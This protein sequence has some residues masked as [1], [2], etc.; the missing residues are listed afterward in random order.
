MDKQLITFNKKT[1][2][3]II[4]IYKHIQ[5]LI[6]KISNEEKRMKKLSVLAIVLVLAMSL[7]GGGMMNNTNQ[8]AEFARTLNRS[9]STGIDAVYSNPAGLGMLD[10]GLYLYF[11]N[12]SIFQTRTIESGNPLLLNGTTYDGTT[13]A[14]VFPNFYVAWKSGKLALS[15][16][17]EPIGGGGS[18]EFPGGLP[19]F[20]G[21]IAPLVPSLASTGCDGY[22]SDI[23]FTGSSLYL[24]GQAGATY[25]INDLASVYLGA[26]FV[27]AKN[28]YVGHLKDIMLKNANGIP[29][30]AASTFLTGVAAQFTSLAGLGSS[31]QA[32]VDAGYGDYTLAQVTGSAL[33]AEQAGGVVAGFAYINPAVTDVTALSISTLQAAYAAAA[34]AF[35][36]QAAEATYTAALTQDMEVDVEQTGTSITPIIG[37]NLNMGKLN[38]GMRY[39]MLTT[40]ELTNATTVDGTGLYPDGEVVRADMPAMLITGASYQVM[41]QLK[42]EGSF[43]YYFDKD[44]DYGYD[45]GQDLVIINSALEYGLSAEYYVMPE[46]LLV[47]AGWLGATHGKDIKYNTDISYSLNSTSLAFGVGY[48]LSPSMMLNAGFSTTIYEDSTTSY[49][50]YDET[51]SKTSNMF[52]IGLSYKL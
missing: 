52:A 39:E 21:M 42:L 45:A 46:K 31:L 11:S 2:F 6:N 5:T 51:Y 22:S 14:P 35:T 29:E 44:A 34:P 25:K 32:I 7:V 4:K 41:P 28:S 43:H 26:R 23:S 18:A 37:L 40:L 49:G 30:I 38:I 9:A 47:S 1:H 15:A 33:T 3:D 12:Q 19:S 20:E 48:H 50:T 24:G 36:V 27:S 13:N 10:D 17:F 8:S 16:G